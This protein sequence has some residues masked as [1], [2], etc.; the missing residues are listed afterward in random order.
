MAEI[1]MYRGILGIQPDGDA[2]FSDGLIKRTL[3]T[4]NE[5]E[6]LCASAFLGSSSIA[7]R[8]SAMA[9]SSLS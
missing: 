3:I 9:S 2:V 6:M 4:E 5:A 7:V 8:Y 1:S